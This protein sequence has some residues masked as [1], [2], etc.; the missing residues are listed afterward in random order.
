MKRKLLIILSILLLTGCASLNFTYKAYFTNDFYQDHFIAPST[1]TVLLN[2][3]FSNNQYHYDWQLPSWFNQSWSTWVGEKIIY[4]PSQIVIKNNTLICT[5]D[6]TIPEKPGYPDIKS[7]EITSHTFLNR[8]YG[9]FTEICMI[10]SSIGWSCPWWYQSDNRPKGEFGYEIDFG[11]FECN[12]PNA[13]TITIHQYDSI[14]GRTSKILGTAKFTAKKDLTKNY[15]VFGCDWQQTYV[16]FYFDGVLIYHYTGKI[17]DTNCF[18]WSGL[19]YKIGD[20][21]VSTYIKQ[22]RVQD[23]K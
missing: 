19:G 20:L 3:D 21:P 17:P 1:S 15:H 5:T 13:F 18:L 11:E 23:H 16:D 9:C 8:S 10:P 22:I 6:N 12:S 4:L 2:E 7:G 14:T